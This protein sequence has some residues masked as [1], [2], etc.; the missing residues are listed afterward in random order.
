MARATEAEL[1][2]RGGLRGTNLTP[3]SHLPDP[4]SLPSI[5]VGSVNIPL[6]NGNLISMI[7]SEGKVTGL[8][9][10]QRAAGQGWGHAH[11]GPWRALSLKA[12][13]LG[14]AGHLQAKEAERSSRLK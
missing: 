14:R 1:P 13:R 6:K 8:F 9:C 12:K 10:F 4:E 5:P 3:A 11:G 2:D 7:S